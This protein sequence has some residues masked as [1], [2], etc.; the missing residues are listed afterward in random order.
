VVEFGVGV[1]VTAV[2]IAIFFAYAGRTRE[3]Q[4]DDW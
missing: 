1:T 2:M 3:I 4:D